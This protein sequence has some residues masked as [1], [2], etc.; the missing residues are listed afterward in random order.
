VQQYAH[1]VL[2]NWADS[3]LGCKISRTPCGHIELRQTMVREDRLAGINCRLWQVQEFVYEF[4][5]VPHEQKDEVIKPLV[6]LNLERTRGID[7]RNTV[8]RQLIK[9]PCRMPPHCNV[10]QPRDSYAPYS[11]HYLPR[12]RL[13][14]SYEG[15]RPG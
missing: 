3:F 4:E 1:G 9:S 12:L 5:K 8:F 15:H 14:R 7:R 2:R 13:W 6:F 10:H 11:P